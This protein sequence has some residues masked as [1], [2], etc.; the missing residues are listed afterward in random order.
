[1]RDGEAQR[2]QGMPVSVLQTIAMGYIREAR[3]AWYAN[4]FEPMREEILESADYIAAMLREKGVDTMLSDTERMELRD[5]S[6]SRL[7]KLREEAQEQKDQEWMRA[8]PFL[9]EALQEEIDFISGIL[10]AMN[11]G[12]GE[13][14]YVC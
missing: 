13:V 8:F 9:R 7:Q 14:E 4:G 11:A 2:Y 12:P 1:M 5:A 10:D 3:E 6:V